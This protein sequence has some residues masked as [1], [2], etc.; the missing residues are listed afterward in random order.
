M[1]WPPL[2]AN[3]LAVWVDLIVCVAIDFALGII[4]IAQSSNEK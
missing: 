4:R 3:P 1:K 2:L